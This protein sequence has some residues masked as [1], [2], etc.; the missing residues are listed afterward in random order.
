MLG[1]R[2]IFSK[3][4]LYPSKTIIREKNVRVWSVCSCQEQG[5]SLSYFAGHL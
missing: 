3:W 4:H 2:A 1:F 5:N